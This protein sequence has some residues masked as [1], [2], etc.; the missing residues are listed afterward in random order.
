M[1]QEFHQVAFRKK[2]Y[3]DIEELQEDSDQWIAYYNNQR[4]RTEKY[5]YGKTSMQ[6]LLDS[7]H[8]AKDKVIENKISITNNTSCQTKT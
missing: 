4:S 3:R 8:L 2:F 5:F 7:I 1:L 6:T